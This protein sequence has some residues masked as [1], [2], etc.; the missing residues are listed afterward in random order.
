MYDE[1]I[2]EFE[3]NHNHT[4]HTYCAVP[5]YYQH[6]FFLLFSYHHTA[7]QEKLLCSNM[8][9]GQLKSI[10]AYLSPVT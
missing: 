1:V 3:K 2:L 9:E 7:Y 8:L 6:L 10:S 5:L 4:A